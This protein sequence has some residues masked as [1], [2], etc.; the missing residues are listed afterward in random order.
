MTALLAALTL[1][2]VQTGTA[3]PFDLEL[4]EGYGPFAWMEGQAS[5]W[6]ALHDS[7]N[8]R[9]EISHWLLEGSGAAAESVARDLRERKWRPQLQAL[10]PRITPWQG[11]W[12]GGPAAGSDLAFRQQD[13]ERLIL[14]RVRVV[15]EHLILGSWEGASADAESAR[16]ALAS[17][18]PPAA[19]VEAP[20]APERDD[21]LGLGEASEPLASL[22]HFEVLLD[23]TAFLR[24][25]V[26]VELWFSASEAWFGEAPDR[27]AWR[28]PGG[29]IQDVDA[30]GDGVFHVE[31]S[32]FFGEDPEV[33]ASFGLLLGGNC[34]AALDPLWLAVPV[35]PES[36]GAVDRPV[37]PPSWQLRLRV[38]GF[39]EGLSWRPAVESQLDE[40]GRSKL[41]T[42]P[43]M[44]PD[45]GWPVGV[46]GRFRQREYAGRSFWVRLGAK[47]TPPRDLT[48]FL[49]ELG[50]AQAAWLPASDAEWIAL[51]LPGSGDRV[52]PGM[53]ILDEER[54]WLQRPLDDRLA[55]RTRRTALAELFASR[56]FGGQLRGAGT[57]APFLDAS[58]AE[59]AA[60]R[61]LQGVGRAAEA[62]ALLQSWREHDRRSGRL[63][64][65][66]SL[67][68]QRD[69]AGSQRLLSR[70]ALVW[71]ALEEE[72]GRPDFDQVLD[73]QLARG[74]YWTTE[75]LRAAL[76]A[77]VDRSLLE[78]FSRHVY[79]K[80][81][82]PGA[83]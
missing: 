5:S 78:F 39:D 19:W 62:E 12:A 70:G 10:T 75:D 56:H 9:L 30:D 25:S 68:D 8:A 20:A 79:G 42:F 3:V 26:A 36:A 27:L 38:N 34:L 28:F 21:A 65:P 66:V 18:R 71:R 40:E 32:L 14:E 41:I 69:L 83:E 11:E 67:L 52:R 6:E 48:G 58:L 63:A 46:V 55:G 1:A 51:S 17:F 13:E 64:A 57:A 35:L 47:G 49:D 37:Q 31:Y 61:L 22:G 80:D 44:A 72:V 33:A 77:A 23:T 7:G 59:Y 45:R 43:A 82:P 29:E 16:Q 76:E 81:A 4:P 73:A 54:L 24:G 74:G 53:I 60:W 15:G 2:A 50:E